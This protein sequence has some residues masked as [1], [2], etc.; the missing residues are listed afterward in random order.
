MCVERVLEQRCLGAL[1][2]ILEN[3]AT[4]Q[5]RE[6]SVVLGAGQVSIR[7]TGPHYLTV[8]IMRWANRVRTTAACSTVPEVEEL[9]ER[10]VGFEDGGEACGKKEV[11]NGLQK[12]GSQAA[13]SAVES[14]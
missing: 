2:R 6:I 4:C 5:W 12:S 3:Q 9:A 10:I 13:V 14:K 8:E 11:V 1:T 7:A